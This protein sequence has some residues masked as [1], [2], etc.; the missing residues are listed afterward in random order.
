MLLAWADIEVEPESNTL[1]AAAYWEL[2]LDW[3]ADEVVAATDCAELDGEGPGA[4]LAAA[5]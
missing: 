4:V 5:D 2:E 1:V 3:P